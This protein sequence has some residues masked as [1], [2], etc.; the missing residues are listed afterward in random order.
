M[1]GFDMER[2][3]RHFL[4]SNV[5]TDNITL[6]R[7]QRVAHMLWVDLAWITLLRKG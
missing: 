5:S 1:L 2:A 7:R 6:C 3:K 4:I